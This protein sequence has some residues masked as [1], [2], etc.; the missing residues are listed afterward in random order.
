[1]VDLIAAWERGRGLDNV[2][3]GLILL[4]LAWPA[5]ADAERAALS[6]GERDR[7]LLGLRRT[8]FGER[9]VGLV[10][11]PECGERLQLE[12]STDELTCAAAPFESALASRGYDLHLRLPGSDDLRIG[13]DGFDDE[14][15]ARALI[16]RCIV[17]ARRGSAP[18]DAA[19]LPAAVLEEVADAIAAA[20][21]Q[22]DIRLALSCE[23]CDARCHAPFDIVSFLWTELAARVE[24]S[25]WEVH[26][27]AQAYGWT[28][29]EVLGLGPARRE[30][31]LQLVLQ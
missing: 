22:A 13:T 17:S 15:A 27:L 5:V 19:L 16:A 1:M 14:A 12:T 24:R 11:C 23:A 29:S 8:L 7:R 21:P 6:I 26:T 30:T 31:Y 25:L 28:E 18:V 20:D 2:D 3:R 4:E 10:A 9:M